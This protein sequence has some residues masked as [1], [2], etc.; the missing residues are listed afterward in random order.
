MPTTNQLMQQ[1]EQ[2]IREK[3]KLSV[4]DWGPVAPDEQGREAALLKKMQELKAKGA[5]SKYGDKVIYVNALSPSCEFCLA[6]LNQSVPIN[7]PCTRNCFFC[8][9][10]KGGNI[11]RIKD[12]SR[13][14]RLCFDGVQKFKFKGS[15]V[16]GG[17]PLIEPEKASDYIRAL[18]MRYGDDFRI[19]LY[20]NGDRVNEAVLK[21]LK[22]AGLN[23]IRF[24]IAAVDYTTDKVE[25]A[26]KYFDE[27]SVEV[28]VIPKDEEKLKQAMI[29]IEKLGV[30]YLNLHELELWPTN[31]EN[32][33]GQGYMRKS[34]K[35]EKFYIQQVYSVAGSEETAFRLMEFALDNNFK[36]GIN[37]CSS[38]GKKEVQHTNKNINMANVQKLPHQKVNK[39]GLIET[40]VVYEPEVPMALKDLRAN[41]VADSVMSYDRTKKRLEL[42]PDYAHYLNPKQYNVAIVYYKP[43]KRDE[44]DIRF[45]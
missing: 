8:P 14:M 27:V 16:V 38:K 26:R 25:L 28:P 10:Q 29:K 5:L 4:K 2:E 18:R 12:F 32:L 17:E 34:S 13:I 43:A 1:L 15:G 24:N 44:V 3:S 7:E 33:K 39:V 11:G 31:I 37:Y 36:L 22:E 9:N 41:N 35:V 30:K 42:H 20:T 19:H 40:V 23:E 45:L 6:G 21:Q